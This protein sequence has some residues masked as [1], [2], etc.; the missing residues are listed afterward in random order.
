[1][2]L[3]LLAFLSVDYH[4]EIADRVVQTHLALED[5][6]KTL[7]PALLHLR[8]QGTRAIQEY[9]DTVCGQMQDASSPG[10][11]IGARVDD[12]ELQATA[13]H[14]E[15]PELFVAMQAAAQSPTHR[16][17]FGTEELVV[18]SSRNDH[19]GVYVSEYL[20]NIQRSARGQALLRLARIMLL[21]VVATIVVNLVF[22]RMAA[23]PLEKLVATVREIAKG[24]L[25]IQAG[26]FHAAELEYLAK[27]I[28][29]MSV[30]LAEVERRR[31]QEMAKARR[32][33]EHLLPQ[34]V[35]VPRLSV[36]HLYQPATEVAGDYYDIL[37]LPDGTWLLCI[38]DVAGHGVPAAM[39]ATMLKTFLLHAAE[40]QVSPD[41]LLS[42]VNDRFTAISLEEVFASMLLVRWNPES[43]MLE[44]AS[45]GH[46]IAWL[47]SMKNGSLRKLSSTG[48]LLGISPGATWTTDTIVMAPGD[49]LLMVTDGVT[50][51]FDGRSEPF[52]RDRLSDL[53]LQCSTSPLPET[54]RRLDEALTAYREGRP[55]TDDTTVLA[56][57]FDSTETRE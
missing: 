38:A 50:E 44:Y 2:T 27:E 51:A 8:P 16:A 20:T 14:R 43:A 37:Q 30:S 33:Q 1:M 46:E 41:H 39:S 19:V 56:I 6:A 15:S 57:Q 3:L 47:V 45:A 49:R 11:H 22:L 26:P 4:R 7:L 13:H 9:V 28:N 29:S 55:P 48:L 23:K 53:F 54:I 24:R 35:A 42:F 10:H 17:R 5:E 32:I 21:A 36:S 25:G 18:G 40:Y 34:Q 12:V 52:G 31:C